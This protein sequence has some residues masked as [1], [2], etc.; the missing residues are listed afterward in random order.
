MEGAPGFGSNVRQSE[1]GGT[2]EPILRLARLVRA[3]FRP[4]RI[5]DREHSRGAA[6]ARTP[7]RHP[8]HNERNAAAARASAGASRPVGQDRFSFAHGDGVHGSIM[9]RRAREPPRFSR[10]I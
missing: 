7:A 6:D 1:S 2:R 8:R 9:A 4:R 3:R 5:A 10:P